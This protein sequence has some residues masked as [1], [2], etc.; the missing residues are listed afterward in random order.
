VSLGSFFGRHSSYLGQYQPARLDYAI[1]NHPPPPSSF[2][3]TPQKFQTFPSTPT[4]RS[5]LPQPVPLFC[6]WYCPYNYC[7]EPPP[8]PFDA[9]PLPKPLSSICSPYCTHYYST[10]TLPFSS[11][12]PIYLTHPS[13]LL[14]SFFASSPPNTSF[15]LLLSL[16]YSFLS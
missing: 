13:S 2:Y 12:R 5:T 4:Y 9:P 7:I 1:G 3:T 10:F 11:S 6:T 15:F 16:D 8:F 14:S